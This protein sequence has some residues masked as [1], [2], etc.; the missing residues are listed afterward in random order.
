MSQAFDPYYKW[1]G[2]PPKDQ[3]PH[4][5]RLLGLDMFEAD[6]DVIADAAEQRMS[7]VRNYQLGQHMLM[8]QQILNELAAA[9]V[10]SLNP[11]K[12]AEYDLYLCDV[13]NI[14]LD[15][16]KDD[17]APSPQP[18]NTINNTYDGDSQAIS[19]APPPASPT[20]EAPPVIA[21]V[22]PPV[23]VESD[24]DAAL[25]LS[26][27]QRSRK[28]FAFGRY[29]KR[30]RRVPWTLMSLLFM[31]LAAL[32]WIVVTQPFGAILRTDVQCERNR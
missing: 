32:V 8:S 2:I 15:L 19:V 10:C 11:Q 23:L 20:L 17:F 29:R 31:M 12:K 24:C 7:H 25:D 6:P 5:Y 27:V 28:S 1:L 18:T 16:G 9:R 26:V 21:V 4:Y 22:A 14:F 13:L 3:P 30:K